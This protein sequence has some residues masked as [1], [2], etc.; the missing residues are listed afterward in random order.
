M[1]SYW[2]LILLLAS[3]WGASYL[4]IKVGVVDIKSAAL[5]DMVLVIAGLLIKK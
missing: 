2:T 1:R 4:F 3:M 5:T